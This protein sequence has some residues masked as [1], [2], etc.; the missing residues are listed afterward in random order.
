MTERNLCLLDFGATKTPTAY[1][2]EVMKMVFSNDEMAGTSLTGKQSN[3][4]KDTETK[5]QL[6]PVVVN[7]VLSEYYFVQF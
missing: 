7:G 5:P 4:H 2:R 1:A 3:A 6:E